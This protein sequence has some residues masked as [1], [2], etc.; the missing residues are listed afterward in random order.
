MAGRPRVQ[1]I[2]IIDPAEVL[3]DVE[4]REEEWRMLSLTRDIQNVDLSMQW[5]AKRRLLKNGLMCITCDV[6][7]YLGA[8]NQGSDGFRWAC[9][10]CNFRKSIRFGSFFARSHLSLATIIIIIYCFAMDYPQDVTKHETGVAG[11]HVIVDW[12]NFL[13]EDLGVYLERHARQIGGFDINGGPVVVEID[14]SKYFHRKYHRG[15]W[16]EGHWVFSGIERVSRKCFLVEVP[17]RSAAT[18]EALICEHILPGTHIISDGWAA[19]RNIEGLADGIYMHSVIVHERNFVDPNDADIHTQ[20]IENLWM[21]A[22]RKLKRQFGTS[23]ALF[24]SYLREFEF[25]SQAV[26]GHIFGEIL[27]ALAENYHV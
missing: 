18:L 2:N 19:Y 26:D 25:R 24:G 7:C 23:R 3:N 6:Q 5:L 20:N 21:R 17:D 8:Y 15:T 22:K 27:C 16:Q 12:F 9:P 13:R 4:M 10:D 1:R 14:E 11:D